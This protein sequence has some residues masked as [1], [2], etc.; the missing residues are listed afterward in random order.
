MRMA[1]TPGTSGTKW[2]ISAADLKFESLSNSILAPES[3]ILDE[4]TEPWSLRDW[5]VAKSTLS[6]QELA[7]MTK[8][9]ALVDYP[10]VYYVERAFYQGN[11]AF[12]TTSSRLQGLPNEIELDLIAEKSFRP[13]TLTRLYRVDGLSAKSGDIQTVDSNE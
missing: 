11:G 5:S 13:F 10:A 4:I 8:T 7:L 6:A 2:S 3:L 9:E 12:M 1:Y